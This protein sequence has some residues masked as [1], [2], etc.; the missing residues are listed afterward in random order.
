MKKIS[1]ALIMAAGRGTRMLPIT[2]SIPKAMVVH[3]G[4]TLIA[5]GISRI[6]KYIENVHIT[7]GYK[8]AML[9]QHVIS[10]DIS[11]IFNTEG[12]GNAW[13]IYNTILKHL[14]EPIF[15]LTCDNVTEID[16][17]RLAADYYEKNCPPCMVVPV[18]PIDGLE[19]D[20]IFKEG[21]IVQ[22]LS[23][24]KRSDL[25]CSGIQILNPALINTITN[26]TE[27]FFQ[28]WHQLIEKQ[29]LMCS[30][31][32]PDKWFAVDSIEQLQYLALNSGE[33][34]SDVKFAIGQ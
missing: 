31:I 15:V 19:G 32:L 20:Y 27:D 34:H 17:E 10:H 2:E 9:A 24:D 18:K 26:H 7:V 1:H 14:N 5:I 28:L 12:K 8:K 23:R 30:D 25:Y 13:W 3:N 11:S 33:A 21:S 6:K 16:F 29:L 4:S 22:E